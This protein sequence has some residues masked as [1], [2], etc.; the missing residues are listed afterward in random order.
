[1]VENGFYPSFVNWTLIWACLKGNLD[2]VER[3][4][5]ARFHQ[6]SMEAEVSHEFSKLHLVR[7]E[8][9]GAEEG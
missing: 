8:L 6:S 5:I 4:Q 7:L 9:R 2:R 3:W 1:M